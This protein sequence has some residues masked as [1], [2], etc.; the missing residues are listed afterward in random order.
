MNYLLCSTWH[1]LLACFYLIYQS[2][3]R[4][5]LNIT[6]RGCTVVQLLQVQF[7]GAA[8]AERLEQAARVCAL[9]MRLD[10]HDMSS[11]PIVGY[12]SEGSES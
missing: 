10:C 1:Y 5:S 8:V 3:V 4:V 2:R 12:L 11:N 9:C 6:V 7:D